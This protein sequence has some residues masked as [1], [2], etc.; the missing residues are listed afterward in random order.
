MFLVIVGGK[1]AAFWLV[2]FA[3]IGCFPYD[4]LVLGRTKEVF[5]R[6][7]KVF[8]LR[9]RSQLGAYISPWLSPVFHVEQSDRSE[10]FRKWEVRCSTWNKQG[11]LRFVNG[12]GFRAGISL[13]GLFQVM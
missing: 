9:G 8:S 13:K 12:N 5:N 7:C 4:T 2:I 6:F 1:Y 11:S 3:R 10:F